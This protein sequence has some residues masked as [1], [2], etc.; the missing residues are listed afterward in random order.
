LWF[1][2]KGEDSR[3]LDGKERVRLRNQALDWLRA[4]LKAYAFLAEKGKE[5]RGLVLRHILHWQ[6]DSDFA[7]VRDEKSLAALPEKER[8]AW[9]K[10]W[11]EVAALRKKVEAKQ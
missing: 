9:R 1:A 3:K 5:D 7:S 2:G 6:Q 4:D 8:D 11:A 10:L